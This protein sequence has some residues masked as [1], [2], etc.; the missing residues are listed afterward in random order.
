[1]T[2]PVILQPSHITNAIADPNF[3]ALMPEFLPL[4]KKMEA[5]HIDVKK[6]CSTCK[7]RRMVDTTSGD[8]VSILNSLSTDGFDRLKKYL[9]AER[10]LIRA[11]DPRSNAFVM[12]EV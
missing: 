4:K 12:K 1:M 5:M 6:G 8:F 9:G 7:K 3:Y 2:R 11:K 10:L